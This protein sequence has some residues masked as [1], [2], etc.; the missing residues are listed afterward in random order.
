LLR[1][2]RENNEQYDLFRRIFVKSFHEHGVPWLD[3]SFSEAASILE[4]LAA[5]KAF[6]ED[7]ARHK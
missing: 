6:R 7:G 2:V 3:G 5:Y 4:K 1:Q